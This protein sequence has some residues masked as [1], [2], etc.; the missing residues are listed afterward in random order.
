VAFSSLG[1]IL[2]PQNTLKPECRQLSSISKRV[3]K[4]EIDPGFVIS[5]EMR[6]EEAPQAYAMFKDKRDECIKVVLKP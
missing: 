5:H 6:L 2:G 1:L 4:G 3:K